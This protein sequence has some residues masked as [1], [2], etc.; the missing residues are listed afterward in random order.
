MAGLDQA[1]EVLKGSAGAQVYN[2]PFTAAVMAFFRTQ[3]G[4]LADAKVRQALVSAVD[5][6]GVIE[7]LPYPT[8]PVRQPLISGQ[9]AYSSKYDQ[10][11][12]DPAIPAKLLK[13]SG[14]LRGPD[15]LRYKNKQP[16][17]FN[18]HFLDSREYTAV[19]NR[20]ASYWKAAGA[21]VKLVP[22][23]EADFKTTLS[24]A[25][26]P[27]R[28]PTYDVLLYG[29]S[30]GA[31]PD[32]YVYWHSSQI[33][34][35]SSVRLNFS[36]YKSSA[37]DV[38]LE[39]GRTRLD[40]KLRVAKYQP[41]LQAWKNDAPALGLYQPRLLYITHGPVHGLAETAINTDAG[42]LANVHNWQIRQEL[43]TP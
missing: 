6:R 5:R 3:E 15:G 41:F 12:Y 8:K 26:S 28:P 2:L 7:T 42:R 23:N 16:L 10:P 20:L 4:V 43:I 38:A 25:P 29:I 32:V 21:S 40:P 27:G 36:Q 18:V 22:Q 34:L 33:D 35:R 1:P 37:A 17:E 11:G 14:W 9:I 39:A 13:D 19:A 30:V 31:D 24:S